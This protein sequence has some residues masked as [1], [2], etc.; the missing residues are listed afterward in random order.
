MP[1]HYLKCASDTC[2]GTHFSVVRNEDGDIQRFECSECGG[3]DYEKG[4]PAPSGS[5]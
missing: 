3:T 5:Q 4:K 1:D 2:Y